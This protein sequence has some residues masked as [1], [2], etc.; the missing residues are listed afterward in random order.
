[1]IVGGNYLSRKKKEKYNIFFFDP[2][3]SEKKFSENLRSIRIFKNFFKNHIVVIH[4]EKDTQ[5]DFENEINILKIKIYGRSKIFFGV[6][7]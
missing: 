1:M 5:D 7:Y 3:F 4:R 6:F 2:P